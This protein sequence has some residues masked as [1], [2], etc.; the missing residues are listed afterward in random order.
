MGIFDSTVVS[1][2]RVNFLSPTFSTV[3]KTMF[4]VRFAMQQ[5]AWDNYFS[6][7]ASLPHMSSF[8]QGAA[9]LLEVRK[10]FLYGRTGCIKTLPART[11]PGA[12][13]MVL[14]CA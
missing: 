4:W 8:L 11:S 5:F 1:S 2:S 3:V 9:N 12:Q 6:G 7:G 10:L 14:T 13:S